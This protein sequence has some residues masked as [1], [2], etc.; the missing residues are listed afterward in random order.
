MLNF[1][2]ALVFLLTYEKFQVQFHVEFQF[3]V[4]GVVGFY[5]EVGVNFLH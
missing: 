1:M 5:V 2:S 3:Q 4:D